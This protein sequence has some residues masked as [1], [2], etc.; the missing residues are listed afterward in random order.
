M[1]SSLYI[2]RDQNLQYSYQ[3]D[4]LKIFLNNI[5]MSTENIIKILRNNIENQTMKE[6]S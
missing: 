4:C 3:I 5:G 6:L 1:C 2:Y